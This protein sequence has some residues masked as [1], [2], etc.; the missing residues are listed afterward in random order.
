MPIEKSS[1]EDDLIVRKNLEQQLRYRR[2]DVASA[3]TIAG[4]QELLG[5]DNFDLMIVDVRLP[6][7]DGTELLKQLQSRPSSRWS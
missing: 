1:L 3:S 2:C 5:K 7:G 4:A 6:D